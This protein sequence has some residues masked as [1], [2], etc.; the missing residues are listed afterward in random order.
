[1]KHKQHDSATTMCLH[2]DGA[3]KETGR[4]S[5]LPQAAFYMKTRIQFCPYL[6]SPFSSMLAESITWFVAN[7]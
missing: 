6:T 2:K 7:V 1:M 4:V 5:F 3:F